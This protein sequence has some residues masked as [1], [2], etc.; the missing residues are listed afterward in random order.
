MFKVGDLVFSLTYGHGIVKD[1]EI[2]TGIIAVAFKTCPTTNSY[3]NFTND[4]KR[5]G[6][7]YRTLLSIREANSKFPE[8]VESYEPDS[9]RVM[10]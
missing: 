4:G 6:D 2:D 7:L 3:V 5:I 10:F 8:Y 9:I 1:I